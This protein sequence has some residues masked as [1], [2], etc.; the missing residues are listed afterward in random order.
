MKNLFVI[1][2]LVGLVACSNNDNCANCHD[3][4]LD[5]ILVADT[6]AVVSDSTAVVD[7][8]PTVAK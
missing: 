5:T 8:I 6:T 7:S 2:A 3:Q 1:V 4:S